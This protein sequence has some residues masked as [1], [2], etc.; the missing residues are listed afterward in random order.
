MNITFSCP[1]AMTNSCC[2]IVV[3]RDSVIRTYAM[4]HEQIVDA[5]LDIIMVI[6][7]AM[8][9]DVELTRFKLFLEG[10]V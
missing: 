9:E 3:S 7:K 1:N 10:K 6:V 8:I 2:T 4:S 5:T